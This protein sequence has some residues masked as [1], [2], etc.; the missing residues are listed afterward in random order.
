MK[1]ERREKDADARRWRRGIDNPW[2]WIINP[3]PMPIVPVR[4]RSRPVVAISMPSFLV[5]ASVMVFAEGRRRV[6]T[7]DHGG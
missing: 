5:T 6:D 7:D 3:F 2:R 4:P 1:K